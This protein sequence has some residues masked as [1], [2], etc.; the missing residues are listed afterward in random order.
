MRRLTLILSDLY[1]PEETGRGAVPTTHDLP[2]LEW[3]L[4]FSDS[5][6]R[7]GDWRRWLASETA[8]GLN[9]VPLA[10]TCAFTRV[11][12][13]ELDSTWLATPVALEARLDH[14]RLLDRGLLRLEESDRA[15]CRE[16]FARVFGPQYRL[17]D[18]GERA[19]FLS[20]LPAAGVHVPDP[21]RLLGTEI[22][23]ALP[24][25]GA[26]ELRLLW[27][28]IEMWLHGAEFNAGRA[29]AGKQ[30]ISALWLWGAQSTPSPRG[31][32]EA[33]RA[34]AAYFGGD[35]MIA[36]LSRL[37][38]H[39]AYGVPK[40]LAQIDSA[41]PHVVVEFAALTGG[42]QESLQALDTNWFAPAKAALA[43]GALRQLDLVANDRRFRIGA[44]PHWKFWR[45]RRA[46]LAS[47][48]S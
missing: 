43:T 39:R 20:G 9:A 37:D 2:H 18:G 36:A 26:S 17:H 35:P 11:D 47:L 29:R 45:R 22:G 14:V 16:E 48:S 34:E 31:R 4:R 24:A 30:R 42:S 38:A 19:F 25:R 8:P 6:E 28:E 40:Q 15:N 21:A 23:P 5:P 27:T 3:L 41:A 32:I 10:I 33:W 12:D 7:I 46:W 1:L 44:R 13:R